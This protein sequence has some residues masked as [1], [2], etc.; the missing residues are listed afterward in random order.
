MPSALTYP[1]V[2]VEEIPS[3]VRTITGVATSITAFVGRAARGPVDDPV[4]ITSYADFERRFG[5]LWR[6]STLGFA[7]RDFF[8]NGGSRAIVV[9]LYRKGAGEEKAKLDATN[10]VLEAA[11]PGSWGN[12]LRARV[13]TGADKV[14]PDLEQSWKAEF[15]D[16]VTGDLFN[17]TVRDMATGVTEEFRNVTVEASPRPVD[18]VLKSE[19]QLVRA[20][21]PLVMP[22]GHTAAPLGTD[23]WG[24]DT[25][26]TG[27]ELPG[28]AGSDG[29]PLGSDEFTGGTKNT[30]KEGL[31]ALEKTDLFNLLCIPPYLESGDV[32]DDVDDGV[33]ADAATY[34]KE[35]RAILLVDAGPD[36]T[37]ANAITELT[38]VPASNNAAVFFPRLR[39]PNPL[40]GGRVESF[41]PCGAVAGIFARTDT[42]RG[43]WKAPAGLDARIVGVPELSIRSPTPRTVS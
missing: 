35:R 1:G 12:A 25:F 23:P 19:S 3:G 2:Y 36:W 7:V 30:D 5:G 24:S 39:R 8:Q 20:L 28:D 37:V 29:D 10:L 21:G 9:R 26:S 42:A 6:L 27:V 14:S 18:Q 13:E 32:I 38:G 33:L 16:F 22:T 31:Y 15:P 11:H 43:V 4:V 17:L 34:C 41:A 40:K